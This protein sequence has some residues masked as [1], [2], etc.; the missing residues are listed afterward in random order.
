MSNLQAFVLVTVILTQH[1][2]R[3]QHAAV[4]ERVRDPDVQGLRLMPVS[5]SPPV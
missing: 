1:R 4:V 3:R 5:T 2:T